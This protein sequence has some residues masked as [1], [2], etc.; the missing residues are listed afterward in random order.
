MFP[1]YFFARFDMRE[2]KRLV[3]YSVGVLNIPV[4]NDRYVSIPDSVIESLRADLDDHESVDAG[5]PLEVG[6]ETT[7]IE[8]SMQGL[9]VKVIKVMPA[10][11]RV[12]ILLEMLGTLVEAELPEHAL[13]QRRKHRLK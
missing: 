12:C 3:S 6:D 2:D 9:T 1:G 10:E 4:F 7:I 13:E 11:G 8:G 5:L